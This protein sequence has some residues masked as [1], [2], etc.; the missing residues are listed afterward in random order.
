ML[1]RQRAQAVHTEL[2]LKR[3]PLFTVPV[4]H[5]AGPAYAVRRIELN[6]PAQGAAS[7]RPWRRLSASLAVVDQALL[8]QVNVFQILEVL[9]DRLARV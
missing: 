6:P 2:T 4:A 9:Q 7:S 8:D 1:V 3:A 5:P